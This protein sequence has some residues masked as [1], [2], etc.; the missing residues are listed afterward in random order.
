MMKST[1]ISLIFI[2]LT[3]CA[4]PYD[5]DLN[6]SDNEAIMS[7]QSESAWIVNSKAEAISKITL[8]GSNDPAARALFQVMKAQA[9]AGIETPMFKVDKATLNTDNVSEVMKTIRQGI[10]IVTVGRVATTAIENDRGTTHLYSEGGDIDMKDSLNRT[11]VHSVANDGSEAST[12][13][14]ID[15]SE[16]ME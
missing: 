13:N 5:V 9:I 15:S 14:I 4:T 12:E 1:L 6:K 3:G 2:I 16:V 10:P 8:E 7:G 11:E